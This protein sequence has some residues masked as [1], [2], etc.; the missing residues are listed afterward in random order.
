MT[1]RAMVLSNIQN[2]D[3]ESG[4][5]EDILR[6][7]TRPV[8]LHVVSASID[9]AVEK[10]ELWVY[11]P[12]FTFCMVGVV[13]RHKSKRIWGLAD[14]DH[15]TAIEMALKFDFNQVEGVL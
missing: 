3:N 2:M 8:S 13:C 10:N 14:T 7:H 12:P 9:R 15:F 6:S 1:H 4:T 11:D 5:F